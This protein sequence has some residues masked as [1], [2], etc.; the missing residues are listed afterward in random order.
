MLQQNTR[1]SHLLIGEIPITALNYADSVAMLAN[2]AEEKQGIDAVERSARSTSLVH[3]MLK[4]K[5]IAS[6]PDLNCQRVV[7]GE[8]IEKVEF[9]YLGL[10]IKPSDDV[11]IDIK[12]GKA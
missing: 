10:L 8:A 9:Q 7:N 6:L 5:V 4:A 12:I 3:S 11:K 1:L 2:S